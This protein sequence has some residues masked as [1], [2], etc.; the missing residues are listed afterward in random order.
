MKNIIKCLVLI[1]FSIF[2]FISLHAQ[3]DI[4]P[5]LTLESPYNTIYV[6]LYYLQ[7]ESYQ[8]TKAAVTISR[9]LKD[10]TERIEA[11]IKIKQILDGQGLYVRLNLLPQETGF[12]DSTTQKHF[13][14]PF[15]EKLPEVY[16]EK[17][18]NKWYYSSETVRNIA[19]LHKKTYPFGT[20]RLL[21][22]FPKTGQTRFL[23][24][25]L[26]QYAA[27]AIL[28]ILVWLG[29]IILSR[30]LLPIIRSIVKSY[31]KSEV[32]ETDQIIKIANSISFLILVWFARTFVPV[33]QLP[34][35][36]AE[37][38]ILAL[39]IL[40]TIIIVI[41]LL[42]LAGMIMRYASKFAETTESKLD[43]QLMPILNRV[44][45][46]VFILG[47]VVKIMSLLNVN[48]TAL[49]AGVSI[50]GL[51]LALAAQDT[52]KNLIGSAMI[53]FDRPFQIGDYVIGE[54][55]DGTITEV[56]FR[57]T[58]IQKIDSS[59]VSVPNGSIA[60]MV[61]ANLGMRIFRLFALNIGI[62][63]DTPPALIEKF[64]E[65]L[66][67]IINNHPATLK[68]NYYVHFNNLE[69]SSL[70]ILF[71]VSLQVPDYAGE[72]KAK[73]ELL[74]GIVRLAEKLGVRF[75]FPSSTLYME[76]FPEKKSNVPPYNTNTE[77]LN[78]KI[79]SFV[80]D[81]KNRNPNTYNSENDLSLN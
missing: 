68:E 15:P 42:R 46:L 80:E 32:V 49:I 48:V 39:N 43:E 57:T 19:S 59:I 16:L 18:N 75:A 71:R 34:I 65:G 21:S 7:P 79:D 55:F 23:G 77:E 56:G 31:V 73:E 52:V 29:R 74:L 6:H 5:P 67:L 28:I 47:G 69:A 8:P 3:E 50:G 54:G 51:A 20:D 2:P 14:T 45:Q 33:L 36:L 22:L 26:W 9:T 78:S 72:L 62:T 66:K 41:V 76:E 24:L 63:Y 70:N 13:Y 53:F 17:V 64:L 4:P 37:W 44:I 61:V 1:V 38:S 27:V 58:R 81:F 10:S 25:L 35:A 11:A 40:I 30:L 12:I 60:N